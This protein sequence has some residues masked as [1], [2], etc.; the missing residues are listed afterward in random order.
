MCV[1][2]S[3][4]NQGMKFL[5]SQFSLAH[6]NL[7]RGAEQGDW[8]RRR[9]SEMNFISHKVMRTTIIANEIESRNNSRDPKS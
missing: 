6:V 1:V 3:L 9:K 4:L 8:K 2:H 5:I 7:L